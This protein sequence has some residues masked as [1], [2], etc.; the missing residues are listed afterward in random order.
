MQAMYPTVIIILVSKFMSQSDVVNG[1]YPTRQL[2][3]VGQRRPHRQLVDSQGGDRGNAVSC[4][5]FA[6]R[7]M[8]SFFAASS[9]NDSIVIELQERKLSEA[10]PSTKAKEHEQDEHISSVV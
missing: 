7:S 2:V 6:R 9:D 8:D 5:N 10:L 4:M 1:T 3:T